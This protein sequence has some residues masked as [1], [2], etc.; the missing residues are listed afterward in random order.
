MTKGRQCARAMRKDYVIVTC[1][2]NKM[3][4]ECRK[5]ERYQCSRRVSEKGERVVIDFSP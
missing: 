3:L 5:T 1:A 4:D 2:L